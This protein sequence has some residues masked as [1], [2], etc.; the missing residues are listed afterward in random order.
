VK[1]VAQKHAVAQ[2]EVYNA[3]LEKKNEA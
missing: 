1:A 2:R 3:W